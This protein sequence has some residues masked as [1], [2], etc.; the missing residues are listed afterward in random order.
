MKEVWSRAVPMAVEVLSF[1]MAINGQILDCGSA[2]AILSGGAEG[3][4]CFSVSEE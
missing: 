2:G 1:E 3:M 4:H